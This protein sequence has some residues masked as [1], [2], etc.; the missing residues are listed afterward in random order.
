MS[1]KQEHQSL[2]YACSYVHT[3]VTEKITL[4]I[5]TLYL[6]YHLVCTHV[7]TVHVVHIK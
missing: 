1:I 4:N 7:W 5:T 6:V 2:T 3:V